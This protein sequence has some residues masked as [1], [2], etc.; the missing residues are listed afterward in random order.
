MWYILL[1]GSYDFV[2]L[3]HYMSFE[4]TDLPEDEREGKTVSELDANIKKMLLK[5]DEEL[6][7]RPWCKVMYFVYLILNI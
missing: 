4:V 7:N 5:S 6:E 3:N 1:I 2:S